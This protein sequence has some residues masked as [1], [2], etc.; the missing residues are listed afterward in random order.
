MDSACGTL[1]SSQPDGFVA[2]R[3]AF[4]GRYTR[5]QPRVLAVGG[6]TEVDAG[7]VD[8][9]TGCVINCE[10]DLGVLLDLHDRSYQ[11]NRQ[12]EGIRPGGRKAASKEELRRPEARLVLDPPSPSR[13][14]AVQ[15]AER[16]PCGS[17]GVSHGRCSHLGCCFNP[18]DRVTPCYYGKTVTARCAPDGSFSLAVSRDAAVPPLRLGSLHL[19]S[20]RGG[21]CGPLSRSEAFVVFHFPRSACGTIVKVSGEAEAGGHRIYEN[22]LSVEGGTPRVPSGSDSR[23]SG[24]FRL[25]IRCSYSAGEPLPVSVLLATPP[26]PAPVAQQGPLALDMRMAGDESYSS[27]Y[28]PR[29]Y[30]VAKLLHQPVPMDVSLLGSRDPALRLL[31]RECWA[32]P[33]ADP[34]RA[35]QWPLLQDGCPYQGDGYRAQL[36][37]LQWDSGLPFPSHHRRFVVRTFPLVDTDARQMLSGPI[38][39][40]CSASACLP[41]SQEPC[42]T[43]CEASLQGR[44][45]RDA[46]G[47][48]PGEAGQVLLMASAGPVD[49]FSQPVQASRPEGSGAPASEGFLRWEDR[50]C[51]AAGLAAALGLGSLLL[52]L[53]LL[54]GRRRE[55]RPQPGP[56]RA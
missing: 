35:P 50:L 11:I 56:S 33:S 31:L 16:L 1:V 15:L 30:P 32:T 17:P 43:R 24:F 42:G 41:S 25:T 5:A 39:F 28:G 29:D 22:E 9:A 8:G 38:Y 4:D 20:G 37:P 27:F 26:P 55:R 21:A 23:A 51:L 36:V 14:S 47:G 44:R 19:L 12:I 40:H 34:L 7:K 45:Q 10:G 48:A 53:L 46:P 18:Q 6:A 52:L 54:R 2:V 49:F 3:T 13:C